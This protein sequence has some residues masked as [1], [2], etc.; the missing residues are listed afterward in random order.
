MEVK[1]QATI[2]SNFGIQKRAAMEKEEFICLL[3]LRGY[4]VSSL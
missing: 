3:R 1:R 2:V 4:K